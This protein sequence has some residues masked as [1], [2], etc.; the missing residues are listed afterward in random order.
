MKVVRQSSWKEYVDHMVHREGVKFEMGR[1]K[2]RP[3]VASTPVEFVKTCDK[4]DGLYCKDDVHWMIVRLT[5]DDFKRLI[6]GD[7]ASQFVPD[8]RKKSRIQAAAECLLTKV[9][10]RPRARE[11]ENS[12]LLESVARQAVAQRYFEKDYETARRDRDYYELFRG[13]D[14]KLEG[15]HKLVIDSM[16]HLGNHKE[17]PDYEPWR[18]ACGDWHIGDGFGRSLAVQYALIE[19]AMPPSWDECEFPVEAF[20]QI[21][22]TD[23]RNE[24]L[25][26]EWKRKFLAAPP[27]RE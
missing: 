4:W 27:M 10:A 15:D 1:R 26:D 17:D 11:G 19:G 7:V 14:L 18:Y 12:W 2:T 20:L 21:N 3:V 6:P 13:D 5:Q 16:P 9:G 23:K 24:A 8:V 25:Y 22:N